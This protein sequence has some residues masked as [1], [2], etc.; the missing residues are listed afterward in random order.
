MLKSPKFTGTLVFPNGQRE[1]RR[2]E[3]SGYVTD[4]KHWRGLQLHYFPEAK[5]VDVVACDANWKPLD[6]Q[7]EEMKQLIEDKPAAA[8]KPA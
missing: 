4:L 2:Y 7:P 3:V 8:P 5:L 6:P 1:K